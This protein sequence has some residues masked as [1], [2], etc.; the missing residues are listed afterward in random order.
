MIFTG[1]LLV[2]K[3][4]GEIARHFHVL[5]CASLLGW[6]A[7]GSWVQFALAVWGVW[8]LV[9]GVERR[10]G[11]CVAA[12]SLIFFQGSTSMLTEAVTFTLDKVVV[13][14]D[15]PLLSHCKYG[16]LGALYV[17]LLEAC[18]ERQTRRH[19]L[20]PFLLLVPFALFSPI[21]LPLFASAYLMFKL[22]PPREFRIICDPLATQ[23]LDPYLSPR[24]PAGWYRSIFEGTGEESASLLHNHAD[25]CY[26]YSNV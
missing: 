6:A 15:A 21:Y 16:C 12:V 3:L 2:A 1:I 11:T 9:R 4:L 23:Y 22:V 26:S 13:S 8:T 19:T 14:P 17:L 7:E 25:V 24:F 20:L 10:D 18:E 5:P